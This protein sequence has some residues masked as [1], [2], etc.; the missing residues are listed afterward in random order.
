MGEPKES[1]ESLG[2][3]SSEHDMALHQELTAAAVRCTHLEKTRTVKM[4]AWIWPELTR[5]IS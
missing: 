2:A 3:L 1:E 5:P 4:L